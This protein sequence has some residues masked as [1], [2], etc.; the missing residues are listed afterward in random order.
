MNQPVMVIE[1]NLC[2]NP[3][4]SQ[5]SNMILLQSASLPQNYIEESCLQPNA[6]E[7]SI[8]QSSSSL[9]S[10]PVVKS[11]N[12]KPK[13]KCKYC[14]KSFNKNF[15]LIQH[16]RSHTGEKPFQCVACGRAFAQKSNVK[17]HMASHKVWLKGDYNRSLATDANDISD[18]IDLSFL[19]QY[20]GKTFS[21]YN[22]RKTHLATHK[23]KQVK[24]SNSHKDFL[25][26]IFL[27][28]Q[29][30]QGRLLMYF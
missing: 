22:K 26:V 23:D 1:P 14:E 13:H 12:P 10:N 5:K 17:K 21:S 25:Q 8:P 9:D 29:M 20:C 3:S 19:C 16:V 30:S 15:D 11:N 24:S 7:I 6:E 2:L 28:L 18:N 4:D 27:G